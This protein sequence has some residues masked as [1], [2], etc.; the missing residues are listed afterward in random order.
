MIF[1]IIVY[2]TGNCLSTSCTMENIS[3]SKSS[4]SAQLWLAAFFFFFFFFIKL[5]PIPMEHVL[6]FSTK[7]KSVHKEITRLKAH[8]AARLKGNLF[9]VCQKVKW[10]F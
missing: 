9:Y 4:S 10:N 8:S 1:Q 6:H 2:V 7:D 5:Y 3:K